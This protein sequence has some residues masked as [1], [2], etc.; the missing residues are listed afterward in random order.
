MP[1]T[2][3]NFY[4][5]FSVLNVPKVVKY[6]KVKYEER[7]NL[8]KL[9]IVSFISL[10]SLLFI[11]LFTKMSKAA[12][13]RRDKY[14][15]RQNVIKL[16]HNGKS[17]FSKHKLRRKNHLFNCHISLMRKVACQNILT[18][19]TPHRRPSVETTIHQK[20]PLMTI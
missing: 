6:R 17:G 13:P 19:L 1:F 15:V 12:E 2:R 7:R 20:H 14:E 5:Q 11:V 9:F 4:T 16:L 3:I 8:S 10:F 18:Q